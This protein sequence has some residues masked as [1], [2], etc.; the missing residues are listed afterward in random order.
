MVCLESLGN[1]FRLMLFTFTDY[2]INRNRI[3]SSNYAEIKPIDI[4]S[5]FIKNASNTTPSIP[6]NGEVM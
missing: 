6:V 4:R 3:Q 5:I 2:V 1:F